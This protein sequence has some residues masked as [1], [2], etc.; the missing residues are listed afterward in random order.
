MHRNRIPSVRSSGL[1]SLIL[2][3]PAVRCASICLI[4]LGA[5]GAGPIEWKMITGPTHRHPMP[6][7]V[8]GDAETI[9]AG[10]DWPNDERFRWLVAD[11]EVPA[12]IDGRSTAGETVAMKINCGDGGEVYVN[13]EIKARFD[14]DH[15]A[16]VP[17]ADS[18][19]PGTKVRVAIQ[20]YGRIQGGDKFD[21]AAWAIVEPRR[22]RERL[23]LKVNPAETLGPVPDGLIGLSQGGMMA[24]YEDATAEKLRE[25][26]FNWFRM[27]N[28]LTMV[29]QEKDG[30]RIYDWEDFDR[31]VDFIYRMEAEPIFAVSYMPA[32]MYADPGTQPHVAHHSAPASYEE[33]EELCYMA[34]H[35][36]VERGKRIPWW[37]VWNEPNT[38][39]IR[40]GPQDTGTERF[41]R[42]Y[43]EALGREATDHEV[44][45]RFEAYCKLYAAT[46]RGV[47]RADPKA[48]IGGPALASGPFENEQFDYCHNGKGFARGL[49][50]FCQEEN[51]PLDFVSWHEYFHP[52]GVI[53][54][55]ARAFR[56]YLKGFPELEK[57][58]QS[59]MIT[60]WNQAWWH[61]RPHD[62]EVGAAWAA[63]CVTRAFIPEKIDRPC[64][65]YVK[66][67]DMHFRGDWSLIMQDNVPKAVYNA[68]K[69]FN[70]LSGEW[71][72]VEGD[73]DDVSLVAAWDADRGRLAIVLVNFNFRY[74]Y[75]R[76][77][78]VS[79]DRLPRPLRS[80]VWREYVIDATR[81]NVWHDR[82]RAEL[83]QTDDG[84]LDGRSFRFE[85]TL[86][87]NS[88]TLL[89][90]L[91]SRAARR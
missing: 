47:L 28:M 59:Y 60:E 65:F 34:A 77:V 70:H 84:A 4:L 49:M 57:S 66:Q 52:A 86:E 14:N 90:L 55:Q 82:D 79:I 30:E 75:P 58:V 17:I 31:R 25:G 62:H 83:M 19:V 51:L 33:W 37:E 54:N 56:E 20:V 73:D 16:L 23:R 27:D 81:S 85:Q 3:S 8:P 9:R 45:R 78:E 67:N 80:G 38:G 71:V 48:K 12:T 87:P 15:P 21:E 46:A 36:S 74:A 61:D 2:G 72:T 5:A 26:G 44:V 10:D 41:K 32:P 89:E 91:T 88:V 7:T 39:W 76:C 29:V 6:D 11:V 64:F 22:A 69:I 35:R 43:S 63:D 24:D 42:I 1:R 53:A 18:A 40:P 68:M 13:G 50:I